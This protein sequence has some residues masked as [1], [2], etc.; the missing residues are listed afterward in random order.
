MDKPAESSAPL[1]EL[2]RERWSPRAF[3]DRSIEPEKVRSLLEAARWAPS[4]SNGQPWIYIVAT[5]D[6]P[7][8]FARLASCLV[9]GNAWAK[10]AA[11]LVLAVAQTNFSHNDKPNRHAFHDVGLANENLVLQATAM[12]LVAHQ[13]AGFVLDRAREL[14]QIPVGNE[15]LT[16]VAV[17][18]PGEVNDLPEPL[19]VREASPRSRKPLAE[20]VF[21]G[22]WGNVSSLL[23]DLPTS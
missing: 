10:R 21:T 5:K 18:Y 8:E 12:G 17:G 23:G 22:K 13:M 14:F 6:E 20:M 9:D 4:S 19:R 11:L 7:E 3:A 15:P 1:H 16:M 2:I